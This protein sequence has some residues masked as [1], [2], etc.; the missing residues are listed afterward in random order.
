MKNKDQITVKEFIKTRID[1][2]LCTETWLKDTPKD[3]AWINQLDLK[4]SNFEIQQ[5]TLPGNKKGG[6]ALI[7]HKNIKAN[8]IESDHTHKGICIMEDYPLKL[9]I[10]HHRNMSSTTRQQHHQCNIYGQITELCAN[11]LTMYDNMVILGDH[12]FIHIHID[13]LSNADS[14]ILVTPCSLLVSNM[15]HH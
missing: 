13:D 5:H 15:S 9:G 1:I 14:H 8:L 3:K 12:I 11:K 2:G 4:Q 6:I 7:H 10:A